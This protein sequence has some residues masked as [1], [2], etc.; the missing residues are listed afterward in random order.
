MAN[1]VISFRLD[2][3]LLAALDAQ[4]EADGT[5]RNQFLL[6]AIRQRLVD[7]PSLD[8][9]TRL[10]ASQPVAAVKPVAPTIHTTNYDRPD[11]CRL[12]AILTIPVRAR[13]RS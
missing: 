2:P 13:G 8:G 7:A 11:I 9:S 1:Q 10:P 5:T 6:L 3:E 12:A 4:A